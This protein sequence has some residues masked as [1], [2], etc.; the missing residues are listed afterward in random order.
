MG[1]IL[2]WLADVKGGIIIIM[3]MIIM[4]CV[5][6]I[7]SKNASI[8]EQK[9]IIR[10]NE[11]EIHNLRLAN[12]LEKA[13]VNTLQ[14]AL[15]RQNSAVADLNIT[16]HNNKLALELWRKKAIDR[17]F[18]KEISAVLTNTNSDCDTIMDTLKLLNGSTPSN[19]I[20]G[21]Q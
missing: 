4:S 9:E 17:K 8:D 10:L 12:A 13:N 5:F 7:Y 18:S 15:D 2:P 16:N 1:F 19:F 14:S 6:I 21:E 3:T 11:K 20:R